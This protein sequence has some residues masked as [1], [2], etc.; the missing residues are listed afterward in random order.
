MRVWHL[1]EAAEVTCALEGEKALRS[2][3]RWNLPGV[4]LIYAAGTVSLCALELLVHLADDQPRTGFAAIPID[5][6]ESLEIESVQPERLHP[7]WRSTPSP[8]EVLAFGTAWARSNR[9]PILRVPS[10][11]IPLECNFVLNPRHPDFA[12]MKGSAPMPFNF[13]PRLLE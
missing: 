5:V 11:V 12:R 10:A 8:K 6:P 4:P 3:G 1:C 13:D 7:R 9:S 2:G